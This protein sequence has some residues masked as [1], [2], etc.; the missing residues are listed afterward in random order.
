MKLI[1]HNGKL[2][3]NVWRE[4]LPLFQNLQLS[5]SHYCILS[6]LLP[7]LD[8]CLDPPNAIVLVKLHSPYMRGSNFPFY[9]TYNIIILI[10]FSVLTFIYSR[11]CSSL[12]TSFSFNSDARR[13]HLCV[14]YPVN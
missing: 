14:N 7:L 13:H 2:I 1:L 12:S 8:K 6:P 10:F 11:K 4:P 5:S 9:S 3:E